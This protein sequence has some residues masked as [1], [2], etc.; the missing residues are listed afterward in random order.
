MD[1]AETLRASVRQLETQAQREGIAIDARIEDSVFV[2]GDSEKLHQLILNL[3]LNA[4]QASERSQTV[5]I[6]L[7]RY[8]SGLARLTVNDTGVGVGRADL[9]HVFEPFFTTRSSGNGLGLAVVKAIV[10]SHGGVISI[11]STAGQGTTVTVML[12]LASE[13]TS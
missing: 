2:H 9:E 1:L 12:P 8:D 10:D 3:V 5:T 11:E 6:A 7:D 4:V 13:A